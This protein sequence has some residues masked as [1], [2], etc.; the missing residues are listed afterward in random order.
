LEA[1]P[2]PSFREIVEASVDAAWAGEPS[3]WCM[4]E[5][6]ACA[7]CEA[8]GDDGVELQLCSGCGFTR[9]CSAACQKADWRGHKAICKRLQANAASKKLLAVD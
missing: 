7:T 2:K 8:K 9:Y 4:T 6:R 3:H 5:R 1:P